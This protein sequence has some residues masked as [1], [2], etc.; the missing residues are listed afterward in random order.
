[1]NPELPIVQDER[2]ERIRVRHAKYADAHETK[3]PLHQSEGVVLGDDELVEEMSTVARQLVREWYCESQHRD[4]LVAE[5]TIVLTAT[6][7]LAEANTTTA[8]RNRYV[9]K[10]KAMRDSWA[11]AA[12]NERRAASE[13]IT[14]L[15]SVDIQGQE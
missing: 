12:I 3:I 4:E 14:A 8:M 7:C 15:E 13:I 1:M 10:V 9:E 2:L 11:T 5:I 6:Y